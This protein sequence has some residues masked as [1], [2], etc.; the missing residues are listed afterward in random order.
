[1]DIIEIIAVRDTREYIEVG[2]DKWKPIPGSGSM[3]ECDRCAK[4]HEVHVEVKLID[5]IHSVIGT[6]C[7]KGDSM[8]PAIKR[9][10]NKAK[11]KAKLEAAIASAKKQLELAEQAR[12]EADKLT[13]PAPSLLETKGSRDGQIEIWGA[14]GVQVW[15]LPGR[16]FDDERLD[17]F[18]SSWRDNIYKEYG[19]RKQPSVIR[20]EIKE[21]EKRLAR[22]G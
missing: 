12:A 1:M 14:D 11:R 17:A 22:C 16:T 19:F 21:M 6:G 8:E 4:T 9:A 13:P 20:T 15:V 7:A 18:E 2:D 3:R 10:S 5:G